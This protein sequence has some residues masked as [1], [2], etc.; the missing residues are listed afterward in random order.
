M[1]D[2]ESDDIYFKLAFYPNIIDP[3]GINER[4]KSLQP[5]L[6]LIDAKSFISLKQIQ[7]AVLNAKNFEQKNKMVSKNIY[8]EVIRCLSPD[9]RLNGGFKFCGINSKTQSIVALTFEKDFPDNLGLPQPLS[10]EELIL[11]PQTDLNIVKKHYK[12]TDEM[13]KSFT[14]EQIVIS[15]NSISV[16]DLIHIKTI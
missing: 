7:F 4:L 12:I 2:F 14:I 16:S 15:T 13:L 9:G 11:N 10:I 3:D 6:L 8:F 1:F 5:D